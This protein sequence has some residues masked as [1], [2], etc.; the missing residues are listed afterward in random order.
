VRLSRLAVNG[1]LAAEPAVFLALKTIGVGP[2]VLHS[3]V[4]ALPA[5]VTG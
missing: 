3:G 5:S 1:M 4:I 2:L